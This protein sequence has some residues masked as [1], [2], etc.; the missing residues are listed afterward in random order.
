MSTSP[1]A[2]RT[3][4]QQV[5][6][7]FKD[8]LA[9]N[10]GQRVRGWMRCVVNDMRSYTVL[11]EIAAGDE[12][13]PLSDPSLVVPT[14]FTPESG[15]VLKRRGKWELHEQTYN[16]NYNPAYTTEYKPEYSCLYEPELPES[17]PLP[18]IIDASMVNFDGN[19]FMS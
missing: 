10:A 19:Q 18:T 12:A 16:Y 6:F 9:V 11:V 2:D 1:S 15:H 7:L 3:H 13:L 14:A 17:T 4:W 5:R 8:P